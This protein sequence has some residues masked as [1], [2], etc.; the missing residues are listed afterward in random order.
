MLPLNF[1]RSLR[2]FHMNSYG[3]KEIARSIPNLIKDSKKIKVF[4][5]KSIRNINSTNNNNIIKN[6]LHL[7]N[8]YPSPINYFNKRKAQKLKLKEC[9]GFN[10]GN[11]KYFQINNN[12]NKLGDNGNILSLIKSHN[13]SENRG[14]IICD[15]KMNTDN[16]INGCKLNKEGVL[17]IVP[18]SE[19]KS[20][21]NYI[22]KICKN[23]YSNGIKKS[24]NSIFDNKINFEQ[25][26]S[27]LN[28]NRILNNFNKRCNKIKLKKGN[29]TFAPISE[30]KI[31]NHQRPS[32][33]DENSV[34]NSLYLTLSV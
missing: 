25:T 17:P 7:N 19:K 27:Q 18:N 6:K 5:Y 3:N 14:K 24:G 4:F 26:H 1:N 11:I 2:N 15:L 22:L 9:I 29:F 30:T 23:K 28:F 13:N 34:E 20:I 10:Q 33:L 32:L 21:K 8:N 31:I 12:N 16:K